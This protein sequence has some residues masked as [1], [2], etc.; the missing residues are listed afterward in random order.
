[1]GLRRFDCGQGRQR[2]YE[3]RVL[4]LVDDLV[5][6]GWSHEDIGI[7]KRREH[8]GYTLESSKCDCRDINQPLEYHLVHG[9][10]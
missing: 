2:F 7:G 5:L 8:D 4:D 6:V 1:M 9:D 3:G 10:D